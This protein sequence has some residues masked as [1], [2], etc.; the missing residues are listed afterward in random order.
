[1]ALVAEYEQAY[2]Q[3][4]GANCMNLQPI[5]PLKVG[6]HRSRNRR[7]AIDRGVLGDGTP[8]PFV[9]CVCAS[10]QLCVIVS[11]H[12]RLFEILTFVRDRRRPAKIDMHDRGRFAAVA[13]VP[14]Y[15]LAIT[16]SEAY[17]TTV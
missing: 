15:E 14:K 4:S 8:T 3:V 10:T 12:R 2:K 17:M 9:L 16:L 13:P 6:S 5:A 7:Y 1:M 11:P